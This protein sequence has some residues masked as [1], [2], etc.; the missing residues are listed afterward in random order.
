MTD[1]VATVS[2]PEMTAP[3]VELADVDWNAVRAAL[4]NFGISDDASDGGGSDD[5][6]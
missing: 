6:S 1:L 4:T 5:V 3:K 2:A